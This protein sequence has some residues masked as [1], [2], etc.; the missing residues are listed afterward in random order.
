MTDLIIE[1]T[2]DGSDTL[3]LPILNEHYHSTKGAVTESEHIFINS[4]LL[5]RGKQEIN[6]L[7][8]GFGT[9]LNAIRTVEAA[10]LSNLNVHYTTL[11]LYPLSIEQIS[12]LNFIK[13]EHYRT[14]H[15]AEW[16]KEIEITKNFKLLK[17]NIDYTTLP[18]QRF[19]HT[20]DVIYF[21]AFA[22]DKQPEMWTQQLFDYLYVLLSKDGILT[23]YSAKGAV[24]RMLQDAG[25]TVERIPGPPGGKR[26]IIRAIK[27]QNDEI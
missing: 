3:Y 6:L 9:G 4:A 22:P 18:E 5:H 2:E 13:E 7:E 16:G 23:T 12:K 21:D 14:I 19:N 1:Q 24:R 11:E 27:K 15:E 10:E 17:L 8:I 20:F 25:F 26:E